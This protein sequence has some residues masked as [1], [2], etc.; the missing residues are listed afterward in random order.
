MAVKKQRFA[1]MQDPRSTPGRPGAGR[2]KSG[3][4]AARRAAE[5][6]P[7]GVR[8]WIGGAR[9]ATLSM[10]IAPVLIGTGAAIAV[11][12]PG[13]L[14]WVRALLCLVVAV[15]LQIGVN[16]A[17]DYSDGIRGTDEH[18]VGPSRL[19]GSGRAPARA[20]LAVALASFGVAALAGLALVI[21]TQHW[22]LLAV[23]ALAVVAAW[24]YTG[25]TRP[26]GYMALGELFV[27]VFFGLVATVG[28]TYVQTGQFTQ[29][30]LIGGIGAG[31]I[32]VA[33]LIVNN[34]R[35]IDQ[36]REAGKRTLSVRMGA[37]A[38]RVTYAALLLLAVLLG[39]WIAVFYPA[40]WLVLFALL[41]VLPAILIVFTARTA[42]ELIIALK[43]T[44][45]TQLV[46][47]IALYLGLTL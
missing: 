32:A 42:R 7:A 44:G 40:A 47:G 23:G 41:G 13:E 1:P 2:G 12:E 45:A 9:P 24:F 35:D 29:E 6:A 31:F 22:W 19:V 39:C 26:Y 3:N 15:A 16:F 18:R 36:D 30:A 21:L 8:D 14:H 37:R 10:A 43:V 33:T 46:Y 11:S 20:V 28:T 27:F 5:I 38:S 4:P 17:N 34:I 25:G